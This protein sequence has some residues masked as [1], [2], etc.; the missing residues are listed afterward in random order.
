[1][2][3]MTGAGMQ[4]T[5]LQRSM[6]WTNP[7]DVPAIGQRSSQTH[8]P[9]VRDVRGLTSGKQ[10]LHPMTYT[11]LRFSDHL[12]FSKTQSQLGAGLLVNRGAKNVYDRLYLGSKSMSRLPTRAPQTKF[13]VAGDIAFKSGSAHDSVDLFSRAIERAPPGVPN[14]FAYEKRCAANA[15][16]GRYDRALADAQF[17]L[18]NTSPGNSNPQT[19]S[20]YGAALARVKIIKDFMRRMKNFESGYHNAT[21][22]LV[23][24][25]RPR[26]HRQIVASHPA[27]YGR[28]TSAMSFGKGLSN[29][30][31]VG[32]LLSWDRD[33]DGE[34]DMTEFYKGIESLGIKAHTK[35]KSAFKAGNEQRGVI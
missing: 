23:C 29:I 3:Y 16:L 24:L 17:I 6:S 33:G 7:I 8:L 30:S 35:E 2:E 20:D 14:L 22:T 19:R 1:M 12:A 21:T 13:E 27:T 5:D 34:I 26:E 18:D 31:S 25:L 10:L 9:E 4:Y 11:K 28:P 32:S 15:E